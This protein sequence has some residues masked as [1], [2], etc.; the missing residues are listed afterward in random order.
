MDISKITKIRD[1]C[2]ESVIFVVRFKICVRG[3]F[4]I[5]G[6]FFVFLI[7]VLFFFW[8]EFVNLIFEGSTFKPISRITIFKI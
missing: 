3:V 4:Q 8:R 6:G 2:M 7:L 1:L 5:K